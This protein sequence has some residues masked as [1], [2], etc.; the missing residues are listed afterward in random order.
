MPLAGQTPTYDELEFESDSIT[1]VYKPSGKNSVLIRSKR[2]TSGVTK[3]PAGDA[4]RSA[5]VT[6]IVLV[7]SETESADLAEREEANQ[8]RWENLL[9]TYP[10][11]FQFSTTYKSLCQCKMGG[12]A[13][14]FKQ[15]QGF[16]VYIN[17]VV[18]K[19]AEA[20]EEE[21]KAAVNTPPPAKIEE[22]KVETKKAEAPAAVSTQ[23]GRVAEPVKETP[24][25]ESP[26]AKVAETP[27]VKEKQTK[28]SPKEMSKEPETPVATNTTKEKDNSAAE[29]IKA[30]KKKAVSSTKSRRTKDPKACRMAC[31]ES[32]QE[33][34]DAFFKDNVKLTKKQRRAAK[35]QT[36]IVKLQL[37][38]DG[39]IKKVL[40]TCPDE[41]LNVIL[42]EAVK[43]MNPWNATVKNGS[44]IKSEVKITLKYD[45]KSKSMKAEEVAVTPRLAPKC[46]CASDSELFD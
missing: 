12:N 43:S 15:S 21:P 44:T 14:A 16:Y 24:V 41:K 46:K 6:E 11:L 30:P 31:Y 8:E 35:K 3:T 42:T 1:S 10:E 13:D 23:A 2:G 7:F 20:T 32:G 17:G 36:P 40:V 5:E 39:S 9:L 29:P 33:S 19:S 25:A 18:P 45:K 4:I 34:L 22:K 27:S 37:N 28:E 26:A 38:V